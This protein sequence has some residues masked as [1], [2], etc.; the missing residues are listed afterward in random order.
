M[1]ARSILLRLKHLAVSKQLTAASNSLLI[2]SRVASQSQADTFGA[3]AIALCFGSAG[4]LLADA[5][6]SDD[7]V[8]CLRMHVKFLKSTAAASL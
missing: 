8:R 7:Q 1:Q 2:S 4:V 3:V 5:V 6:V